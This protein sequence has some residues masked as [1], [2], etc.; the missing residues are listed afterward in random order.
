MSYL[1]S[2]H[3]YKINYKTVFEYLKYVRPPCIWCP[4]DGYLALIGKCLVI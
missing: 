3:E 1:R 2:I 4:E